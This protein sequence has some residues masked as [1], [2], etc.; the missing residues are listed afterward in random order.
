ML[1]S[2]RAYHMYIIAPQ[3]ATEQN[4]PSLNELLISYCLFVVNFRV[5]LRVA[6]PFK[7]PNH[8]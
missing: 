1:K 5:E 2:G 3:K 4:D 8:D 6:N 7:A